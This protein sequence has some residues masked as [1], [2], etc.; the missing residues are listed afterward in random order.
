ME[1]PW[2]MTEIHTII[3]SK[4]QVYFDTSNAVSETLDF[5]DV[6]T[7]IFGGVY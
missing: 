5:I 6:R 3:C 7:A 4:N 2:L 1:R